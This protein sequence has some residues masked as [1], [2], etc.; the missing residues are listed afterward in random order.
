MLRVQLI[1]GVGV[2]KCGGGGDGGLWA[3]R[4]LGLG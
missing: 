1:S 2:V 3:D 4:L